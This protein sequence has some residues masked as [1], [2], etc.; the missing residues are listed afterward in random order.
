[1]NLRTLKYFVAIADAGS[2]TGAASTIPIAQPALTRQM[3]ELEVELGV[4]LLERRPRGVVLTAAG[5]TFYAS[6]RRILAEA[7]RVREKLAR[8]QLVGKAAVTI[9]AP[10]TLAGLLLPG[11]LETSSHTLEG[12]ELKSRE[13]FTPVLL[14]WLERG[15]IDMAVVTNPV[16]GRALSFQP[17]LSEPFALVSNRDM[18]FGELVQVHQIARIPLLMTSL[19]RGIVEQQLRILGQS[20]NV[21]WEIDSVDA[22]RQLVCR[23]QFATI[24]PIS[25]FKDVAEPAR[26]TVSEISSVQLNRHLALATRADAPATPAMLLVQELIEGEF[27]RL[28]QDGRFSFKASS[29]L[30]IPAADLSHSNM[31]KVEL[32][33]GPHDFPRP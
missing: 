9:G 28:S 2:F 32:G 6:A 31:G 23:G 13:A 29:G 33:I 12:I 7:A 18:G 26:L 16:G 22:I 1:M 20:L 19:H 5:A 14:E 10:P 11:L 27:D 21:H 25:V 8:S 30:Q 24:M 3:R 4:Q 15:V 17:L